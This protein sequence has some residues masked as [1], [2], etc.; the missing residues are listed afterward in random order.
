VLKNPKAFS[1]ELYVGP[2]P[3]L[4]PWAL[5]FLGNYIHLYDFIFEYY[6]EVNEDLPEEPA[7]EFL[8]K[9][10]SHLRQLVFSVTTFSSSSINLSWHDMDLLDV[11][12]S[13][14]MQQF[15]RVNQGG[16]IRLYST[17]PSHDMF[18]YL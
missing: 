17:T 12:H 4:E 15:L 10:C 2:F 3:S 13:H 7:P 16:D 8:S 14:R 1:I 6:P 18:Y 11:G 9:Q 5:Y